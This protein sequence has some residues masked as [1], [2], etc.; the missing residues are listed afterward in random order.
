M[1]NL[2]RILIPGTSDRIDYDKPE[3]IR[4]FFR[5]YDQT[6]IKSL[7][8]ARTFI[9]FLSRY[10]LHIEKYV[11]NQRCYPYHLEQYSSQCLD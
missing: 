2:E 5:D 3:I 11:Y 6:L 10:R 4:S 8:D 7:D 1:K 9:D